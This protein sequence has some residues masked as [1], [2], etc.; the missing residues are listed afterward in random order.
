M[1]HPTSIKDHA[2]LHHIC[3]KLSKLVLSRVV[4]SFNVFPSAFCLV[5][6]LPSRSMPPPTP[7]AEFKHRRDEERECGCVCVGRI[8]VEKMQTNQNSRRVWRMRGKTVQSLFNCNQ[9][10]AA[11]STCFPPSHFSLQ[12]CFSLHHFFVK[13]LLLRVASIL[14]LYSIKAVTSSMAKEGEELEMLVLNIGKNCRGCVRRIKKVAS[15]VRGVVGMAEPGKGDTKLIVV[16]TGIDTAK[17][18][19]KLEKKM[20]RKYEL[21]SQRKMVDPDEVDKYHRRMEERFRSWEWSWVNLEEDPN[22][23]SIL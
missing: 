23:C 11:K 14:G 2:V 13:P 6:V 21:I 20:K 10:S 3:L 22:S 9:H 18:I 5:C 19:E 7:A 12:F 4:L 1:K 8:H 16:G 17:L 15:S